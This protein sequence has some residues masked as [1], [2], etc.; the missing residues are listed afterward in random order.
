MESRFVTSHL[1]QYWIF[2]W[3]V[4]F[5]FFL[6]MLASKVEFLISTHT[7]R[8]TKIGRLY[9]KGNPVSGRGTKSSM[10]CVTVEANSG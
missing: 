3:F 7:K 2:L 1:N 5:V 10:G 9:I 8:D 4:F 6:C